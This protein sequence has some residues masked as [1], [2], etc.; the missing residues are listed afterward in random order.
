MSDVVKRCVI[1]GAGGHAKS[2]LDALLKDGE[3]KPVGLL[4]PD[5]AKKG[6]VLLGVKI[7]GGEELIP[8]LLADGIQT[9]VLGVGGVCDNSR[10]AEIFH[11][12]EA[13]G[14]KVAGVVHPSAVV[15]PF[16]SV[17]PSTQILAHTVVGPDAVVG[18]GTILNTGTLIEHD[19]RLGEFV[20]LASG[21]VLGGGCLIEDFA[22]IGSGAVLLQGVSVG[23]GAIVGSGAVVTRN[24]TSGLTVVGIPARSL[25]T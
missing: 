17:H 18:C 5:P 7:L 25:S 19:C 23:I 20:H 9:A 1:F 11:K 2:V 12:A 10:R 21:A 3:L 6:K 24:V 13:L 22:H 15:S 8:E 14:F 4:D 16:A